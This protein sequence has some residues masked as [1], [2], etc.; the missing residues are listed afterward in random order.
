[1][2]KFIFGLILLTT[3]F[4]ITAQTVQKA[5]TQAEYV[6]LLYAAR[7]NAAKVNELVE[8]IR[9]RGIAFQLTDGLRSLTASKS[10]NNAD[11]RRTLDEA[12]RRKDSPATAQLPSEE[13]A[14]EVLEKARLAT[15]QA[16]DE[17]PD[18]LVKQL[19]TRGYGY[20][21]TNNFR[22]TDNLA[23]AV[24]YRSE[25][26]EFYKLLNVNGVQQNQ[27]D[28]GKDYS[29]VG[30]A[31]STGEFVTV[32][33]TIFKPES[34]TEF[35][36]VDTDVLRGKRAVLYQFKARRDDVRQT[37]TVSG[38][39]NDRTTSG[40]SGRVWIDRENYRVLR[41]ET[42]ATEI[43]L[44]FPMKTARRIIDYDWVTINTQN[45][46]LPLTAEVRMVVREN[47]EE[48][49]SRNYIRFR[50][51]QKFDTDVRILGDEEVIE[52]TPAESQPKDVKKP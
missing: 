37:L 27:T 8:T 33:T 42:E 12:A 43:P 3:P 28:N 44:D 51:Y 50:N 21:G 6:Q 49:E 17:M 47:R 4:A 15:L 40:I 32:L 19:I 23:V 39:F 11:L 7:G 52:D 41:V 26:S 35:T 1:M 48:I 14:K 5:L 45:Y 18:F 29:S 46:L 13:E 20:A 2:R 22:T 36:P 38:F 25:G 16:A 30:G 9:R 24:G 34:K 31:S 10:A